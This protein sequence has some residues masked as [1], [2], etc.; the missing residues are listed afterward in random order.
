MKSR[1][2]FSVVAG[3]LLITSSASAQ[4][5]AEVARQEQARRKS[6]KQPGKVYTNKDLRTDSGGASNPAET[7]PSNP[8]EPAAAGAPRTGSEG[9]PPKPA[10]PSA[11]QG[12][13]PAGQDEAYWRERITTARA[14]QEQTQVLVDAMQSRINVLTADFTARDDPAQRAVIANDRDRA[15]AEL[16]RLQDDLKTKMQ[17]ISDIEE[18]ARR[19]GVP[20]GW[21]R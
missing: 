6:I 16:A 1:L 20:P 13:P 21:L 7:T 15:L 10:E 18:E 9:S 11:P 17:A 2:L 5:L 19:A 3:L 14:A 4:S 8:A 12:Q